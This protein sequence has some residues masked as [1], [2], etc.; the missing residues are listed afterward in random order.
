ANA[1]A[2]P[3][4]AKLR[5]PKDAVPVARQ[6]VALAPH[7]ARGWLVLG[8]AYYR[9]GQWSDAAAALEEALRLKSGPWT[10]T[11]IDCHLAMA[12][13]RCGKHAEARKFYQLALRLMQT[14][15]DARDPVLR[16]ETAA[17]LGMK[18]ADGKEG[19]PGAEPP[20]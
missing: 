17:V 13:W 16:A 18:D 10:Q 9:S 14:N 7:L 1:L 2:N 3:H 11:Q 12:Q 19:M 5:A 6:A 4:D 8:V 15:F 20:R